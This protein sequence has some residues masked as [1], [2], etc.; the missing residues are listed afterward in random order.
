MPPRPDAHHW[1]GPVLPLLR[2]S[3]LVDAPTSVA[4]T[5]GDQTLWWQAGALPGSGPVTPY[6]LWYAASVTKQLTAALVAMTI[7]A[8]LLAYDAPVGA[9]LADLPGW[10]APVRIRHLLH[11]TSGLPELTT[12]ADPELDNARVLQRLR[13]LPGLLR[14]PGRTF[15]YCNTGYVLLAC[16]VEVC[17][18]EPF[19]ALVGSRI[20]APLGLTASRL[21][22]APP[23]DLPGEPAPPLT[24]GDGGWWTS[25]AELSAWLV[26]LNRSWLGSGPLTPELVARLETPGRLDDWTPLD[27]AWGMRASVRAGRRTLTHGGSWSGWLAKTV[28]QPDQGIA[29]NVLSAS[30]DESC[31]SDLGL[32]LAAAVG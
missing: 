10:M 32:A 3:P 19:R 1:T 28:R 23:V 21:G 16:V 2:R 30:T 7:E 5:R 20:F 14:P 8:G 31:V 24:Q 29:V 22:G 11:H 17:L 15:G 6:S 27:Y 4:V 25:A 18:G 26:A 12:P 9:A 13:E